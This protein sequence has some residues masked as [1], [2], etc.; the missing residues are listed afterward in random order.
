GRPPVGGPSP[1]VVP[2]ADLPA[3]HPKIPTVVVGG[4]SPAQLRDAAACRTGDL[5]HGRVQGDGAAGT[6]YLTTRLSLAAGR[7]PCTLARSFGVKLYDHG[8][9]IPTGP[10]LGDQVARGPVLITRAWPAGLSVGWAVSHVCGR[11]DNTTI[12]V[13]LDGSAGAFDLPGFGRTTCNPGEPAM[14]SV[15]TPPIAAGYNSHR[16]SAYDGLDVSGHLALTAQPGQTLDFTITLTSRHDLGL[17]PCP[18]Y[19]IGAYTGVK[20][21]DVVTDHALN[22]AAVPYRTANGTPYLPAGVP[23]TFAMQVEAPRIDVPKLVWELQAPPAHPALGGSITVGA[24]KAQ[25]T[26]TGHVTMDGG[27]APGVT[28][29]VTSGTVTVVGPGVRRIVRIRPDGSYSAR[30][31]A[32]PYTLLVSTRQWNG[33]ALFK[34]RAGVTGNSVTTADISLPMK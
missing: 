7:R 12:R 21:A 34:D 15:V 27:P 22:C 25:G 4:P 5:V 24:S 28:V 10:P 23:V 20:G 2:W 11:Y 26:L 3:T 19:R 29:K 30:L 33:G 13:H 16:V 31:P 1:V 6:A 8:T 17:A 14:E 9:L 18:D 32:G